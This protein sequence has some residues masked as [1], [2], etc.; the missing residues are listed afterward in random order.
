ML[1]NDPQFVE[2]ARALADRAFREGGETTRDRVGFLFRVLTGRRASAAEADLLD[3][4]YREQYDEFA[5]WP[6]PSR[7]LAVGDALATLRSPP[8]RPRQ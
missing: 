5:C 7:N 3:A 4:M 2:A 1:L 8:P 6:R